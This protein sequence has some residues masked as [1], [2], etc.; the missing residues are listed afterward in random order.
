MGNVL[1]VH[2][3]GPEELDRRSTTASIASTVTDSTSVASVDSSHHYP[4]HNLDHSG[5][6]TAH[7]AA[8]V[9]SLSNRSDTDGLINSESSFNFLTL[10]S[11]IGPYPLVYRQDKII[12]FA[13]T[14]G[15]LPG[16][17]SLPITDLN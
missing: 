7:P 15:T 3:A 12:L 16:H 14:L 5:A 1:A 17:Y 2:V 6:S 10:M 4:Y 8:D 11:C 9:S 13:T